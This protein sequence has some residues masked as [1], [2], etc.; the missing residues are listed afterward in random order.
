VKEPPIT[1]KCECGEVRS[2]PYGERWVCETCGRRW[3]TEQ[4]PAEEYEALL[5]TV[6][7]Y[8]FQTIVFAAVMLAVFAPLVVF[9]DVRI[10]FTA[11]IL[12]FA[13]AFLLRPWQRQR[14]VRAVRSGSRWQLHPE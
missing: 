3:N 9:V 12:G 8:R 4:I 6:R 2:V 7:R 1:I 11:L 13:W 10:G 14:V 5:R